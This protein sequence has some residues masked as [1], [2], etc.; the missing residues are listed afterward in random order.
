MVW[1][2]G[3]VWRE[4]GCP[5]A[6]EF[7]NFTQDGPQ[8]EVILSCCHSSSSSSSSFF[9]LLLLLPLPLLLFLVL[10]SIPIDTVYIVT[11]LLAHV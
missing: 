9:L 7:N 1:H 6:S 10:H 3:S 2:C 4:F 8:Q 11:R 5:T